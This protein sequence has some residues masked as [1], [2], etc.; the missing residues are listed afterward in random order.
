MAL[1]PPHVVDENFQ[2]S[3]RNE[4]SFK[5]LSNKQFLIKDPTQEPIAAHSTTLVK[6]LQD[7]ASR[8]EDRSAPLDV[9]HKVLAV[10]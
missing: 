10:A 6:V 2:G 8:V 9:R 1:P 5:G 3:Y 7:M 4:H